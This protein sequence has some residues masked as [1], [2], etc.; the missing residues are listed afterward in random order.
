MAAGKSIVKT[1]RLREDVID[2]IDSQPG[3]N[4]TDKFERMVSEI[5]YGQAKRLARISELDD[6]IIRERKRLDQLIRDIKKLEEISFYVNYVSSG[7]QDLIEAVQ[8]ASRDP[9]IEKG[10]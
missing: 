3:D 2:Y 6:C 8:D 1:M 10:K 9:P 7:V 5:R 4:F